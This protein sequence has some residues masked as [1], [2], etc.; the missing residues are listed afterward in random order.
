MGQSR[1]CCFTPDNHEV[2]KEA[3]QG[4]LDTT[5]SA[6][7]DD[8]LRWMEMVYLGISMLLSVQEMVEEGEEQLQVHVKGRN[9]AGATELPVPLTCDHQSARLSCP[10]PDR[11]VRLCL[12][13]SSILLSTISHSADQSLPPISRPSRCLRAPWSSS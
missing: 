13:H 4:Y 2:L 7:R 5:S 6:K 3:Q 1:P 10:N 11:H 9:G 8:P 12:V